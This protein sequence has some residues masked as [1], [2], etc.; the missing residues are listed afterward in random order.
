MYGSLGFIDGG[1]R[2]PFRDAH[3][4]GTNNNPSRKEL[5]G[6][7]RYA[8]QQHQ[9]ASAPSGAAAPTPPA[10]ITQ[11]TAIMER[12]CIYLEDQDRRR[13]SEIAELRQRITDMKRDDAKE[14]PSVP[15][16]VVGR[17]CVS[18]IE[19]D[20]AGTITPISQGERLQLVYPMRRVKE[21]AASQIWMARRNVCPVLG[22][23][24]YTQVLLFQEEPDQPDKIFVTDFA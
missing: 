9:Q 20:E 15:E 22:A 17:V 21:G 19:R 23:V 16:R 1:R 8:E 2:A 6:A 12:R 10:S 7:R 11:S 3:F 13:A 5:S 18:T 14:T 24:T 4:L